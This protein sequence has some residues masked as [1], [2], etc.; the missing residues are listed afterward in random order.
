MWVT[1]DAGQSWVKHGPIYVPDVPMGV[2]QP[3]PFVTAQGIIPVLL[4]ASDGIGRICR[5]HH[6]M[7]KSHGV[8]QLPLILSIAT[9]VSPCISWMSKKF[10]CTLLCNLLIAISTSILFSIPLSISSHAYFYFALN[11][12]NKAIHNSVHIF[13]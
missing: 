4:R 12:E 1:S 3:V 2:I 7:R 5:H 6:L 13:L 9:L 10:F 8:L 11:T